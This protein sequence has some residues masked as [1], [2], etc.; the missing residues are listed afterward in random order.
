MKL[1]YSSM[2]TIYDQNLFTWNE[3]ITHRFLRTRKVV[4]WIQLVDQVVLP[5]SLQMEMENLP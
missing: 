5:P 1:F 3:S 4:G 2:T